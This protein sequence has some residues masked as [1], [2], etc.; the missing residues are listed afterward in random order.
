M[1]KSD[2]EEIIDYAENA[3]AEIHYKDEN[4]AWIEINRIKQKLD[5]M[6]GSPTEIGTRYQ[7]MCNGIRNCDELDVKYRSVEEFKFFIQRLLKGMK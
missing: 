1:T 4:G 5:D 6:A 3:L 2:C 7:D